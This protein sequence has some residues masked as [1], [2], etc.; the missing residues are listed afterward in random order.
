MDVSKYLS[1]VIGI[2][3]II[4]SFAMF[5]NMDTFT[6][7]VIDMMNNGPLLLFIGFVTVILGTLMV[8]S[9][10]KWEMS[11]RVLVTIVSWIVFIKGICILFCAQSMTSM[12]SQFL[13]NTTA[14]YTAL[15]IDFVLGLLFCYF[16]FY[17]H[18]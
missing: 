12:S 5:Y 3:L 8:V 9:H 6:S 4:V 15:V 14:I 13:A 11:W 10:N 7:Q 16:G 17:C 18:D 1:K 2:Y